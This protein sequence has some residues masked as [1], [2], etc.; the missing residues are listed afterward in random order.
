MSSHVEMLINM[1]SIPTTLR[2]EASINN[3]LSYQDYETNSL[4][5]SFLLI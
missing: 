2:K 3:I 5:Q 4:V 1:W